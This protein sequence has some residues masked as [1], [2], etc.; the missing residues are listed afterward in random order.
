M[1]KILQRKFI[2]AAMTAISILLLLLLGTIN[3]INIMSVGK[4]IDAKLEMISQ[5][6]GDPNNIPMAPRDIPPRE[7]YGIKNDYDTFMSSNFFVVRF[8]RNGDIVYTDVSRI[9]SVSEQDAKDL[10]E[11]IYTKNTASGKI[12]SFKYT[13]RDSRVGFGKV[14]VFLDTSTDIYSYI[15]VLILSVAIGIA[16]WL[17]MLLFVILLSKRAIRPIAENIEKQKQFVTN[18]GHEIKTPLA[19]IQSN[20]EAMELYNGENKWSKNI[21]EQTVRLNELMKNLLTLAR[22]DEN[23]DNLILSNCS[24]SQLLVDN[25]ECFKE[26]L[27][28]RGITLQTS[29]QPMIS[30]RANKEHITQLISVL[31]D[32]AVKYTNDNGNIFVSLEGNDRR[33]KLQFKNTCHQLPP[34]PPDKLFDRFYRADEARTQKNGGYGIGLSVA[35]SITETYK[36][37]ISAEYE[38]GNTIVFTIRF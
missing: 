28:L 21:K 15:R 25:T 34:V 9:S 4:Q 24:L 20:T 12:D 7:P 14:A 27:K 11:K 22:M 3:I 36:G 38:N 8:D 6:E 1:I 31:M 19:I 17:F 35:Q 16:C 13:F 37:K 23:S 30:F 26:T 18:A 33:I 29:I 32:N 10:A 5:N 2:I